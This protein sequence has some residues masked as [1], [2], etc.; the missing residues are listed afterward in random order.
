[1]TKVANEIIDEG[2]QPIDP[3]LA[4]NLKTREEIAF[5]VRT[6]LSSLN[7]WLDQDTTELDAQ[8]IVGKA[9]TV[10]DCL[11]PMCDDE[12]LEIPLP[13]I[14]IQLR[15]QA[16]EL[17]AVLSDFCEAPSD[18]WNWTQ[19]ECRKYLLLNAHE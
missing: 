2:S 1:M 17:E 10:M 5:V 6:F 13:G 7:E 18:N 3:V 16:L 8:K 14:S 12:T 9:E 11:S 19:T 15:L 4:K